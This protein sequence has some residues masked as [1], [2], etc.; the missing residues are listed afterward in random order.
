MAARRDEEL[1]RCP[2]D[3]AEAIAALNSS[4]IAKIEILFKMR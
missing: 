4:H 1:A 2:V 3:L